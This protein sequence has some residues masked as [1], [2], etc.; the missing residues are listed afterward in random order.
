MRVADQELDRQMS[1][2]LRLELDQYRRKNIFGN[3][4]TDGKFDRRVVTWQAHHHLAY[5]IDLCEQF[6]RFGVQTL[7]GRR[8]RY[9][10]YRSLEE[11]RTDQRLENP[12]LLG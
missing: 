11:R 2:V 5:Y 1:P 7:S 9:T 10:A 12:D 4:V 8:Q 6:A 3:R